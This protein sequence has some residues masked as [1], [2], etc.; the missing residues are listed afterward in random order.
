MEQQKIKV[1]DDS[2]SEHAFIQHINT[3]YDKCTGNETY[4]NTVEFFDEDGV[5]LMTAVPSED[6]NGINFRFAEDSENF[7]FKNLEEEDKKNIQILNE[8]A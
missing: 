8:N 7:N 5:V 6:D 2:S 4:G 1:R 3:V